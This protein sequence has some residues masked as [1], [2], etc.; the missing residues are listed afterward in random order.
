MRFLMVL[1]AIVVCVYILWFKPEPEQEAPP[2][3]M[4]LEDTFISGPL[5]PYNTAQKFQQQDYN[6]ALDKHR[7]NMDKQEAEDGGG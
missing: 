2:E 7:E 4:P 6:E 5:A 3:L 1:I